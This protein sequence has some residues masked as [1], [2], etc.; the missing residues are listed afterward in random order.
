MNVY[1]PYVLKL[2]TGET[3]FGHLQGTNGINYVIFDP[4][5]LRKTAQITPNGLKFS[6][7]V[8]RYFSYAQKRTFYFH[9]NQVVHIGKAHPSIE[10]FINVLIES[11]DLKASP[12]RLKSNYTIN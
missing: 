8:D 1:N 9:K 6:T 3:I 4:I 10:P 7:I 2:S 12:F 5:E 11:I